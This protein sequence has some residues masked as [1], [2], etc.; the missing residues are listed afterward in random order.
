MLA[1][2]LPHEIGRLVDPH[3]AYPSQF[4]ATFE[5]PAI[6]EHGRLLALACLPRLIA[7]TELDEFDRRAVREQS[8]VVKVLAALIDGRRSRRYL[9]SAGV[10]CIPV[11]GRI[12]RRILRL[13]LDP[14]GRPTPARKAISVGTLLSAL[15]IVVAFLLQSEYFQLGQLPILDLPAHSLVAGFRA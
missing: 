4:A 9:R 15:L 5:G 13:A 3:D 8:I 1:G 2:F 6:R 11:S 10:A 12:L 7:G 14:S